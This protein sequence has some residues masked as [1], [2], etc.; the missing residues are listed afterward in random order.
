M[1]IGLITVKI[2]LVAISLSWAHHISCFVACPNTVGLGRLRWDCRAGERW[3]EFAPISGASLASWI[4]PLLSNLKGS[5]PSFRGRVPDPVLS[6]LLS[7]L[8][9]CYPVLPLSSTGAA[10]VQGAHTSVYGASMC[11]R[12]RRMGPYGEAWWGARGRSCG[13]VWVAAFLVALT[14]TSAPSGR[15]AQK[16]M[17]YGEELAVQLSI[18]VSD[19]CEWA[20]SLQ[21]LVSTVECQFPVVAA[22]GSGLRVPSPLWPGPVCG[23]PLPSSLASALPVTEA[24]CLLS[25]QV[26]ES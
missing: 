22:A 23:M 5:V 11:T 13:P 2:N 16:E 8:F 9:L 15:R 6:C 17:I 12:V 14:H 21:W 25:L 7:L 4:A 24:S 10:P 20:D 18:S 1:T 19:F 3:G 26:L